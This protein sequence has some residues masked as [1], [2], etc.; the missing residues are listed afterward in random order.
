MSLRIGI[1]PGRSTRALAVIKR[2]VRKFAFLATCLTVVGCTESGDGAESA[3]DKREW[4]ILQSV[5]FQSRSSIPSA[6]ELRTVSEY[7]LLSVPSA[8][9]SKRIWVMLW[10]KSPPYYKQMPEGNFRV[11]KELLSELQ[12]SRKLSSTVASALASHVEK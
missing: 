9:G 6:P 11:P 8:D 3:G 5:E 10:P 7:E 2:A 1:V 4:S 12:R